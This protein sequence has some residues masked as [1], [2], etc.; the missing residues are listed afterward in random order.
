MTEENTAYLWMFIVKV[1]LPEITDSSRL[2]GSTINTCLTFSH[3]NSSI[4]IDSHTCHCPVARCQRSLQSACDVY[5]AALDHVQWT[6]AKR[7]HE[8]Q[9][10]IRRRFNRN[11]YDFHEAVVDGDVW[12]TGVVQSHDG[13]NGAAVVQVAHVVDDANVESDAPD[14]NIRRAIPE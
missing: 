9:S 1:I 13:R 4:S 3:Y 2:V 11:S 5:W 14:L 12:A 8:C 10:H 7:K 6:D